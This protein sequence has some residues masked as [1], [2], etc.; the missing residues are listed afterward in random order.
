MSSTVVLESPSTPGPVSSSPSD[1]PVVP[2]YTYK[3]HH[4][5]YMPQP[6]PVRQVMVPPSG[7]DVLVTCPACKTIETL[8]MVGG[9]PQRSG[10]FTVR[11][12][13]VYHDCGT[14]R[15][16]RLHRFGGTA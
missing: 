6:L 15:P 12:G 5:R 1:S 13:V 7:V 11:D 14:D 9:V 3:R 4:Y 10:K 2:Q 16:C 8:T